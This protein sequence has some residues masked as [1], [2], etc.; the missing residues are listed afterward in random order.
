[1]YK[2]AARKQTRFQTSKGLLTV[3]QLW[4]LSIEELD[5]LA[6]KLQDDYDNSKGRSFVS[7][8]SV[9]DKDIKLQFDIVL[10]I[11]N[12]KVEEED[13]AQQRADN[14]AHNKKILEL[15]ASK[16][17]AELQGK[18]VKQLEAMLRDEE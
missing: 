8:R 7:K 17:D 10:D 3:E 18:S 12:T 9:K 1:M 14:K 6:V 15:I 2:E 13:A 4:T 11:L 16:K 5:K